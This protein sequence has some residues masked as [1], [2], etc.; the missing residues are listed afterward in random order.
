MGHPHVG[1]EQ[2]FIVGLRVR[3]ERDWT[4]DVGTMQQARI[5]GTTEMKKEGTME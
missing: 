3:L 4:R 5:D 2:H 1:T